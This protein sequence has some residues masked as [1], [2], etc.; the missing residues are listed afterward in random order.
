MELRRGSNGKKGFS[1]RGENKK[2]EDHNVLYKLWNY[3]KLKKNNVGAIEEDNLC[4]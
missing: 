4:L 3:Q 2:W 1:G